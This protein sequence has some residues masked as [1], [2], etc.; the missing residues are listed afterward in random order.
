MIALHKIGVVTIL[1][2]PVDTGRNLTIRL[3]APGKEAIH[4]VYQ[5][6]ELRFGGWPSDVHR[7]AARFATDDEL[8]THLK[9]YAA[10]KP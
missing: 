10:V 6:P 1:V 4:G 9:E 5:G 8:H 2:E 3:E 7:D